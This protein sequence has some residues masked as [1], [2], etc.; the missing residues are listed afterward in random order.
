MFPCQYLKTHEISP[1]TVTCVILYSQNHTS[2]KSAKLDSLQV[3]FNNNNCH[4]LNDLVNFTL[5]KT[6][7]HR[8]NCVN[9]K[10]FISP[11]LVK[12]SHVKISF[13]RNVKLSASNNENIALSTD[14]HK[15]VKIGT[16]NHQS[17]YLCLILVK[18]EIT[19][20]LVVYL[21]LLRSRS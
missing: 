2:R 5:T 1:S 7:I 13:I 4:S 20:Y 12:E 6:I 17:S 11:T 16:T 10:I 21:V 18:I 14:C 3:H 19:I 9:I 8:M 15:K